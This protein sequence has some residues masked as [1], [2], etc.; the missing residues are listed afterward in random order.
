MVSSPE[1][2][3]S[4]TLCLFNS[5]LYLAGGNNFAVYPVLTHTELDR[6]TRLDKLDTAGWQEGSWN[7]VAIGIGRHR[8]RFSVGYDIVY[9][10]EEAWNSVAAVD[11]VGQLGKSEIFSCAFCLQR[12]LGTRGAVLHHS[13]ETVLCFRFH[14]MFFFF[15][16]LQSISSG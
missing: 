5:W 13:A 3:Q 8:E 14:F 7:L 2:Q 15:Y 9:E 1:Y 4:S 16:V 12:K 10:G 11:Q 6:L